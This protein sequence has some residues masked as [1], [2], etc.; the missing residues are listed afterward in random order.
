M[1]ALALRGVEHDAQRAIGQFHH[2]APHQAAWIGHLLGRDL[3]E[4]EQRGVEQEPGQH[5]LVL[6]RLGDVVDGGESG[7]AA[8]LASVVELDVPHAAERT[9]RIEEIDQAAAHAA[10]RRDVELARADGLAERRIEQQGGA[11]EGG[12]CIV[13]GEP[14]RADG[15]AVHDVEGMGE[16]FLLAIDDQ[17]DVALAPACDGLRAMPAGA[18]KPSP[19]K[20]SSRRA[21]SSSSAE[22]SMK[23]TPL[24]CERGGSA[25]VPGSLL[26]VR[27]AS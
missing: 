13:D 12:R 1:R 4:I 9:G 17:V 26:P 8:R 16:A 24:A 7:V 2:L 6:H 22:N 18:A 3:P 25:G 5:L 27:S 21:A 23:P 20:S 19:A 15:R 10:H 14:Q 11:L